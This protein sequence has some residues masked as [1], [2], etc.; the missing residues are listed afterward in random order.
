MLQCFPL[1]FF[2]LFPNQTLAYSSVNSDKDDLYSCFSTLWVW[3]VLW[4]RV[5]RV[6]WLP[7]GRWKHGSHWTI[8]SFCSMMK[9][10]NV[11]RKNMLG[12]TPHLETGYNFCFACEVLA[13]FS[14]PYRGFI[15]SSSL[16]YHFKPTF[17]YIF[18]TFYTIL[19]LFIHISYICKFR[20]Q[21]P[22][23]RVWRCHPHAS[24]SV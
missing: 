23:L 14:P 12:V 7:P 5:W 13:N 22:R 9:L 15:L 11:I 2:R 16:N 17:L 10:P 1:I 3:P 21:L 24:A 8:V 20:V 19:T 4:L 6:P 18:D